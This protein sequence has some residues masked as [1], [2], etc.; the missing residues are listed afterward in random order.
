M[1]DMDFT[2]SQVADILG[3]ERAPKARSKNS[4]YV[5]CPICDKDGY[6]LNINIAKGTWRCVKCD[7]H[8]G[9]LALYTRFGLGVEKYT[10]EAG[11]K[12]LREINKRL[13]TTDNVRQTT[14]KKETP[15]DDTSHLTDSQLDTIYSSLIDIPKLSLRK[16]HKEKLL[17]RGLTEEDIQANE[18]RTLPEL[19]SL[20]KKKPAALEKFMDMDFDVLY[21]EQPELKT[22]LKRNIYAGIYIGTYLYNHL[23]IPLDNVPGFF[24]VSDFWCFRY[25][26]GILIPVR[27]QYGEIVNFQVRTDS[28]RLRYIT[29]S[30]SGFNSGTVGQCRIH[31]PMNNPELGPNTVI[32]LTEGA[33]KADVAAAFNNNPNIAYIAILGV[34]ATSMLDKVLKEIK[35]SGVKTIVNALDMDKVTNPHVAKA[36][37]TLRKIIKDN[38][39]EYSCLYWGKQAV[40]DVLSKQL[41]IMSSHNM[42]VTLTSPNLFYA[43]EKNTQMLYKHGYDCPEWSAPEIKGI[44]D[45]LLTQRQNKNNSSI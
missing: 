21:A 12:A 15:I 42:Y 33:L 36:S 7:E 1:I 40:C 29:N 13:G 39:Y 5:K 16:E 22:M 31:F 2:I 19:F 18:Y 24:K 3:L 37:K 25:T 26:P 4:F 44:D 9:T 17:S 11:R 8:G 41:D 28:G 38:G 6:H 34:S 27:N 32:R 30:S 43:V 10:K 23:N 20:P 45:F 14:R 35:S